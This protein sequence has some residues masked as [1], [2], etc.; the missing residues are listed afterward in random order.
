M[1]CE[2]E[3]RPQFR[4]LPPALPLTRCPLPPPQHTC[5]G[6]AYAQ[7]QGWVEDHQ[8]LDWDAMMDQEMQERILALGVCG[9]KGDILIGGSTSVA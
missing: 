2:I 3:K 6:L 8:E 4:G 7:L 5:S 1:G 9:Q